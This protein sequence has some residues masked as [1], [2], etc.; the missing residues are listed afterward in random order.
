MKHRR[1][2]FNGVEKKFEKEMRSLPLFNESYK[3]RR[4]DEVS[5]PVTDTETRE[6]TDLNFFKEYK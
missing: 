6:K 1:S 4:D 3:K 5:S 2:S